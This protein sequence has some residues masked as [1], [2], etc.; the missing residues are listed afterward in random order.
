MVV[1]KRDDPRCKVG[2]VVESSETCD[3]LAITVR[4]DL[5]TEYG[6]V[7]PAKHRGLHSVRSEHRQNR[8]LRDTYASL[9]VTAGVPPFHNSR[10]N[11][12]G[13]PTTMLGIYADPFADD[14]SPTGVM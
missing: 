12:H 2:D 11:G 10:S 13:K 6:Q 5:D 3:G 9:C 14:H 1:G 4:F 7:G 8:I